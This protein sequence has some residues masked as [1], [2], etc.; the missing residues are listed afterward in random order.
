MIASLLGLGVLAYVLVAAPT[1]FDA[2]PY[3]VAVKLGIILLM[4]PIFWRLVLKAVPRGVAPDEIP[5]RAL[6]PGPGPG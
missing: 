1:P 4:L 2:S 3:A 5:E 6:P